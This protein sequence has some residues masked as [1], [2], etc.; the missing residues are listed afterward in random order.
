MISMKKTNETHGFTM[1]E[2]VLVLAI[3]GLI[4]IMAFVAL[5]ALQKSQRDNDRKDDL[6]K[7]ISEVKRFQTSNRGA[8]P[9]GTDNNAI[10]T[11]PDSYVDVSYP[12]SNAKA[13][14]WAEFYNDYLGKNFMDPEGTNYR[15]KVVR[16]GN[17]VNVDTLCPDF[18][19]NNQFYK[20]KYPNNYTI[21]VVLEAKCGDENKAVGSSSPRNLAVLYHLE[22]SIYCDAT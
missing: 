17:K 6:M 22:S 11:T 9:G 16:C 3:A 5:P 1:I 21:M 2:V 8:L 7:F 18:S 10:A 4:F 13:N 14:S 20:S 19:L 12:N 15:L